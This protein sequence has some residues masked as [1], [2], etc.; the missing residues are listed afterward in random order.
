MVVCH[1][2]YSVK[3]P[4]C[5]SSLLITVSMANPPVKVER[6]ILHLSQVRSLYLGN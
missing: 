6:A 5:I 4:R 1:E 3:S 2:A